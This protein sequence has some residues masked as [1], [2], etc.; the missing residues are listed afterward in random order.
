MRLFE[1]KKTRGKGKRAE[2]FGERIKLVIGKL[3]ALNVAGVAPVGTGCP[4]QF[5]CKSQA[6]AAKSPIL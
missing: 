5:S 6:S 2:G 3:R 1:L 4:K